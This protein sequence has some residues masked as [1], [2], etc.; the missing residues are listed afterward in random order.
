MKS[1]YENNYNKGFM[2]GT[3]DETV[4]CSVNISSCESDTYAFRPR[5][6]VNYI[7]N[8][9]LEDYWTYETQSV[10]KYK[11]CVCKSV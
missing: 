5:I 6:V 9:G 11:Y 7:V 8:L 2:V 10:G 1:W 4:D 3:S